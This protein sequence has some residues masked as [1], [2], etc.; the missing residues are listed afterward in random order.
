MSNLGY[1]FEV[2]ITDFFREIFKSVLNSKNRVFR[3]IGSGRNKLATKTGEDTLLEGD[4]SV[5]ID[6]LPK[7]LLIECKHVKSQSNKGNSFTLKKEWVDQALH[8]ANNEDRWSIVA[9]KFKHVAPNSK[10][11]RKFNWADGKFGNQVHFCIPEPH[12]K[13]IILCVN[14]QQENVFNNKYQVLS[15]L[16]NEELID[17][18]KSRLVKK[19][20][21]NV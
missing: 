16:S 1:A 6:T 12:F 19:G 10:G 18:L 4:V 15:E 8:E 5:E 9:I 14:K 11:F 20:N 7:N 21:G 17:E 2:Y 13:E 3:I